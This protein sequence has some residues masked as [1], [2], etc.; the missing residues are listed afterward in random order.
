[1]LSLRFLGRVVRR[2]GKYYVVPPRGDA[3]L[4]A[5]RLGHDGVVRVKLIVSDDEYYI[6]EGRVKVYS[7]GVRIKL[8]HYARALY[9]RPL[10]LEV[11]A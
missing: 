2:H 7:D 1:M 4:L 10:R 11:I 6:V 5:N 9:G 3:D 8:P